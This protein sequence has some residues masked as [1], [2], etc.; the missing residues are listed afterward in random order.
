MNVGGPSG[1]SWNDIKTSIVYLHELCSHDISILDLFE[2][3]FAAAFSFVL[4]R[5]L[6]HRIGNSLRK[7]TMLD[8]LFLITTVIFFAIAWAYT[9]G[10]DRL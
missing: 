8:A 7:E 4:V 1:V 3:F 2:G 5:L 10:C 9:L 6:R